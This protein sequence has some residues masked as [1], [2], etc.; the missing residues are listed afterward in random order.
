VY[1][2]LDMI[3]VL[4]TERDQLEKAIDL[5]ENQRDELGD[6]VVETALM[7]LR[8]KLTA[9]N[10][11][12]QG[13]VAVLPSALEPVV[14]P[15]TTPPFDG[16]RRVVT[17]LFCDVNGSTAM[18]ENLDPEEW[19]R[20]IQRALEYITNPVYRHG[21]MM[22]EVRGDGIL[23]FFGAP[24]AHEDDPQRAVLTGLEIIEGVHAFQEQ[25]QHERRL[26]FN[27]RVGI[28]TGLVVV[29]E[30]TRR[31]Q[32]EYAAFGDAVNLAARMEQTA[33]RARCRSRQRRIGSLNR[34][35]T[36]SHSVRSTSRARV[37][38]YRLTECWV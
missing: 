23:A 17:I 2:D 15:T 21:G 5:L 13:P 24:L 25:L 4:M 12:V 35:L 33:Q 28:H 29:G 10:Q 8:A 31:K 7:P 9:L 1:K 6:S 34:F 27:V 11:Q 18:A 3:S 22:A 19:A 38:R 37:G 26:N 14:S 16:E 36:V 32:G 30:V 20:T